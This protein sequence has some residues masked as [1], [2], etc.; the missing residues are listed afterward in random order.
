MNHRRRLGAIVAALLTISLFVILWSQKWN[1]YDAFRLRGYQPSLQIV[2]L[3]NDTS[4]SGR[5]RHLF[6][7]YHPELNDKDSFNENCKSRGNEQTI[8]LGCYVGGVGIYVYNVTDPRLQG[9][10]Q[11]TS[12]HEMLHAAYG[13][14]QGKEKLRIDK[15][16]N[17]AYTGSDN[18]RLKE[19]IEDYR[20]SGADITNELHSI[21]GTEIRNLPPELEQYYARYFDNRLTVVGFSEKYEQAFT[22]RKQ[23]VLDADMKLQQLKQQIDEAQTDLGNQKTELDQNRRQLDALL[24]ARQY[25][26]YNRGVPGFN[27]QVNAYNAQVRHIGQLIDK[28]NSLVAERNAIATEEGELIKA[29]DSR[30][31]T[32]QG[33]Q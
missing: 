30:P 2:Q 20:K 6:Y 14:L 9:I 26:T 31:T 4:M 1:L 25:E 18:T 12:A 33:H 5:G 29:I 15:L 22:L 27:A 32:I 11:V 13:R 19:T 16:L 7:V 17:Q 8:V 21:L 10:T 3:A 23:Q 24:A 28:Y